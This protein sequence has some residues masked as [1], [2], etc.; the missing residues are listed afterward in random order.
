VTRAARVVVRAARPADLP[1]LGR[2]GAALARLHHEWDPRRFFVQEPMEKG[3]AWWL[4]KEL[5]NGKAVVLVAARGR[6]VLGYAYGT[7]E[8]RDWNALRD[9]CGVLVDLMVAPEERGSGTG[10][11][12]ALAAIDALVAKGAPRVVL[13]SAARNKAAQ[14]FFKSLG[15][16][17]TMVEMTREA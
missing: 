3:Y 9:A 16:R 14:R 6:R 1:A 13:G 15:F 8:P 11:L 5:K 7:L 17:P 2:L 4:G 12:L 10:R